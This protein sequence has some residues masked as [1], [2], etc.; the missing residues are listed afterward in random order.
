MDGV[1]GVGGTALLARMT[2]Q[3]DEGEA[4]GQRW[5]DA[6]IAVREEGE[7]EEGDGVSSLQQKKG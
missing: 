1:G 4:G 5:R 6:D 7:E 3:R 2:P